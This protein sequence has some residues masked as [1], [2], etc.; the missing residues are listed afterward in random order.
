MD[1]VPHHKCIMKRSSNCQFRQEEEKHVSMF[2]WLLELN[3]RQFWKTVNRSY[4]LFQLFFDKLNQHPPLLLW[5]RS[6]SE[7]PWQQRLCWRYQFI[8]SPFAISNTS[9]VKFWNGTIVAKCKQNQTHNLKV[10]VFADYI[11]CFL[12]SASFDFCKPLNAEIHAFKFY[13]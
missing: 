1:S 5:R 12:Y 2:I 9:L 13:S 11:I 8:A 4:K 3:L 7:V 10:N 6:Q